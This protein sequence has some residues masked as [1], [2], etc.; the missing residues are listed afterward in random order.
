MKGTP[1]SRGNYAPLKTSSKTC[2]SVLRSRGSALAGF[3]QRPN[4]A[5]FIGQWF[6]RGVCSA[7]NTN[8][9][10]RVRAWA[11]ILAVGGPA[12]LHPYQSL[13]GPTS[14]AGSGRQR[15]SVCAEAAV[16]RTALASDRHIAGR[17]CPPAADGDGPV[18]SSAGANRGSRERG[19]RSTPPR[20]RIGRRTRCHRRGLAIGG[21]FRRSCERPPPRECASDW[22]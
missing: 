16:D 17:A 14:T 4:L 18:I 5:C 3:G 11:R 9:A 21:P 1:C 13:S 20:G 10:K 22:P 12:A 15:P 2:I 8:P 7:H 19:A 6:G